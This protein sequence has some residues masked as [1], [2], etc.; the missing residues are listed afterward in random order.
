MSVRRFATV[1]A[2]IT[3]AVGATLARDASAVLHPVAH[4]SCH[5]KARWDHGAYT[6]R[7]TWWATDGTSIFAK[8][9]VNPRTGVTGCWIV[10]VSR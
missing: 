2:I 5:C 8:C 7:I 6:Y 10:R 3:L 4:P 9:R 1:L